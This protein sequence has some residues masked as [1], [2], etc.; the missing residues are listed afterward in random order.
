MEGNWHY[1]AEGDVQAVQVL[2]G[3]VKVG[4]EVAVAY[5]DGNV[6]SMRTGTVTDLKELTGGYGGNRVRV[7]FRVNLASSTAYIPE[8]G[9]QS[10]E[11][12]DRIVLLRSAPGPLVPT[13]LVT[14]QS[15]TYGDNDDMSFTDPAL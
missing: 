11:I 8:G 12:H 9:H 3:W 10:T 14:Q 1:N 5:R 13:A 2:N 4:D 7:I 15:Q 6:A